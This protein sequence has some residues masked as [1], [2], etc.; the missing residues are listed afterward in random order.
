M[1]AKEFKLVSRDIHDFF[2]DQFK[3]TIQ[4]LIEISCENFTV[5]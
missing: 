5:D 1:T 4:V 2:F 3:Y